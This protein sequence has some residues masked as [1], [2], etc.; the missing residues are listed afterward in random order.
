MFAS[1]KREVHPTEIRED[2]SREDI[3]VAFRSAMIGHFRSH[4]PGTNINEATLIASDYLNH[5]HQLV[6]LLDAVSSE[7]ESSADRLLS[8]RPLSYEE[9]FSKSDFRDKNLAIAAYRKAPP[10]TRALFDEAVARFDNEALRLVAEI[11]AELND[12]NK[13][14]DELNKA[15]A[16]AARRLR[17]RIDDAHAIATGEALP[18]APGNAG[19]QTLI[20]ALFGSR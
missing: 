3:A 16:N 4:V 6:R 2:V 10:R 5:F 8:W 7:P 1:E 12:P 13:H 20:A 14:F 11:A 15:C 9:H 17:I 19:G 18:D